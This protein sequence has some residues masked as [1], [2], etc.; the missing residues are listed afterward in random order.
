[1]RRRT[2]TILAVF[3]SVLCASVALAAG[4]LPPQ[5]PKLTS[6][7][8]KQK[9]EELSKKGWSKRDFNAALRVTR[10]DRTLFEHYL[11]L[12][13][14]K[15]HP[16]L[17]AASYE[18]CKGDPSLVKE[19]WEYV[20]KYDFEHA[21]VQEVMRNFPANKVL[22][23]YYFAY[24]V[25]GEQVLLTYKPKDKDN[26]TPPRSKK[27]EKYTKEEVTGVFRLT[28]FNMKYIKDYFDQR[29]AGKKPAA[30]LPDIKEKIQADLQ[31]EIDAEKKRVEEEERKK[32]E[33]IEA[34]QKYEELTA[35]PKNEDDKKKVKAGSPNLLDELLGNGGDKKEEEKQDETKK[36]DTEKQ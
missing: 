14:Q 35:K 15:V 10:G 36:E 26:P 8:V 2:I 30:I 19:Y 24:R 34:K 3:V 12:Y 22:R 28:R 27:D 18:T 31:A 21:E 29:D 20:Q 6:A 17:I 13:D 16:G 1:M 11:K 25:G 23:W 4:G 5:G 33:A 7:E 32:Q 9:Y